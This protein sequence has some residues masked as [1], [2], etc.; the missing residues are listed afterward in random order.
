MHE[1]TNIKK[2]MLFS[3]QPNSH[4]YVKLHINKYM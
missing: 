2:N 4:K 1:T 3:A